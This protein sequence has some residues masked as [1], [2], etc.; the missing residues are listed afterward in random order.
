MKT[1]KEDAHFEEMK[2]G[3]EKPVFGPQ[4][5]PEEEENI[6]DGLGMIDADI[7]GDFEGGNE[8]SKSAIEDNKS[9]MSIRSG[10]HTKDQNSHSNKEESL[11]EKLNDFMVTVVLASLNDIPTV[12]SLAE[13]IQRKIQSLRRHKRQALV[14]DKHT[15]AEG[16]SKLT[17]KIYDDTKTKITLDE[18]NLKKRGKLYYQY[19]KDNKEKKRQAKKQELRGAPEVKFATGSYLPGKRYDNQAPIHDEEPDFELDE[20][21]LVQNVGCTFSVAKFR[22]FGHKYKK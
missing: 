16:I 20:D 1:M 13:Q 3:N 4:L 5:P 11:H 18:H 14:E 19:Y 10:M 15:F 12:Q 7:F 8:D 9:D 6:F 21:G 22:P 2:V 17:S